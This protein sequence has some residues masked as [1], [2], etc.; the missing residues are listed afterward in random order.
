MEQMEEL[1]AQGASEQELNDPAVADLA[2]RKIFGAYFDEIRPDPE[3]TDE[4]FAIV[5]THASPE[6]L[7]EIATQAREEDLSAIRYYLDAIA[8]FRD[9]L[10]G[11]G[12]I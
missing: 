2:L 10:P 5:S 9:S 4:T 11:I 3:L 8:D 1:K 6:E 7:R 12:R